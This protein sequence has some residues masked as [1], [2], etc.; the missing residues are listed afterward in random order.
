M[1]S[2]VIPTLDEER[3]LPATLESVLAS[4]ALA[5]EEPPGAAVEVLVVDGG[6]GDGTRRVVEGFAARAA[7]AIRSL[8]ARRGR[9]SQ[10][11]AGAAAAGGDWLLFL[12]ADTRL[13]PSALRRIA[14]LPEA[15][16]AGCFR[17]RFASRS[18]LLAL[19][20]WLHNRRFLATRVIYGDQAMF[21][22]R[23]L[24]EALGGFSERP[25]EDIDFSLRLKAATRP[26]MLPERVVTDPRKF[27]RLG[28]GRA[29]WRAVS[30][31][32]RFRIGSDVSGDEF[33]RAYR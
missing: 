18:R 33:F 26:V 8:T 15:A 19:L 20:S 27:D 5:V 1:I 31:L 11:N 32:V 16:E 21:V 7:A 22:R 10:M 25:M 4:A 13:Q 12:H 29:L 30:L 6:S 14:A 23:R 17:Q 2:V 9:G 3:A 24:F 28:H